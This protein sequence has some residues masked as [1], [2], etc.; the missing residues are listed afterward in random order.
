MSTPAKRPHAHRVNILDLWSGGLAKVLSLC[1]SSSYS[2]VGSAFFAMYLHSQRLM[3]EL[4]KQL[5]I[6]VLAIGRGNMTPGGHMVR[7]GIIYGRIPLKERDTLGSADH[8]HSKRNKK[9]LRHFSVQ[10]YQRVLA[11]P[12]VQV[13]PPTLMS[14]AFA[15]CIRGRHGILILDALY[16]SLS[17]S[18][19]FWMPCVA[20]SSVLNRIFP[21]PR[22]APRGP[23]AGPL[24]Q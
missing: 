2:G 4:E 14:D 24:P 16:Q 8:R 21:P 15:P 10:T 1:V 12:Q 6:T 13:M 11:Q 5:R 20:W 19:S 18:P 17:Y 7:L 23:P 22:L 3:V 9:R